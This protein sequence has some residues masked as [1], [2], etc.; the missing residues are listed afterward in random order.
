MKKALVILA[1]AIILRFKFPNQVNIQIVLDDY[2][3]LAF[4]PSLGQFSQCVRTKL[5][6]SA[7][8]YRK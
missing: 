2:L 7:L 8:K 6:N 4:T 1:L 3:Y 5:N